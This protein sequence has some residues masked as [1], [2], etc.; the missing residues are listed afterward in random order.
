MTQPQ[1]LIGIAPLIA[2]ADKLKSDLDDQIKEGNDQETDKLARAYEEALH[3]ILN[4]K[5]ETQDCLIKK[6]VFSQSILSADYST[7]SLVQQVFQNLIN[8]AEVI[9]AQR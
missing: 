9:A 1:L 7:T 6:L 4:F 8:D 2:Q 5:C 3:R